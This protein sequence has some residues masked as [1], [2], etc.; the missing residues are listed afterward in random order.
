MRYA[1]AGKPANTLKQKLRVS[2][3][4]LCPPQRNLAMNIQEA[5]GGVV[6]EDVCHKLRR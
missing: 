5:M 3:S 6:L 1:A 2:D 4:T